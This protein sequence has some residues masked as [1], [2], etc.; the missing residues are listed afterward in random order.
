MWHDLPI[1]AYGCEL[2][3]NFYLDSKIFEVFFHKEAYEQQQQQYII[4][5]FHGKF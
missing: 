3:D 4:S 2:N 5:N 1:S